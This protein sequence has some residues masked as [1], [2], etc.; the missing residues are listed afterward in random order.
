MGPFEDISQCS[1]KA[2]EIQGE[3]N[4]ASAAFPETG[5]TSIDHGLTL[6]PSDRVELDPTSSVQDGDLDALWGEGQFD[7]IEQNR[8]ENGDLSY[9]LFDD[10][11]QLSE[12]PSKRRKI[13]GGILLPDQSAP[14]CLPR[15]SESPV[16]NEESTRTSTSLDKPGGL[17]TPPYIIK[18]SPTDSG[19]GNRPTGPGSNC[20]L[21]ESTL[22]N[23]LNLQL[24]TAAHLSK[25]VP[26]IDFEI[27]KPPS[28]DSEGVEI[29]S[30][31]PSSQETIVQSSNL[32]SVETRNILK[33]LTHAV[34]ANSDASQF[35]L[36]SADRQDL[37][38]E[39]LQSDNSPAHSHLGQFD[40]G[41]GDSSTPVYSQFQGG[42]SWDRP[43]RAD[44]GIDTA[45]TSNSDL[46]AP[47]SSGVANAS[48]PKQYESPY[49]PISS[50]SAALN[51][52]VPQLA[53][54]EKG[55]NLRN[56]RHH[57]GK[58]ASSRNLPGCAGELTIDDHD[59]G[60]CDASSDKEPQAPDSDSS[61]NQGRSRTSSITEEEAKQSPKYD[62]S[63]L[64]TQLPLDISACIAL[65]EPVRQAHIFLTIAKIRDFLR[66]S[67]HEGC[68]ADSNNTPEIV[69][70]AFNLIRNNISFRSQFLALGVKQMEADIGEPSRESVPEQSQKV[71]MV[72][73][74]LETLQVEAQ[75]ITVPPPIGPGPE[76]AL[77][78][79]FSRGNL[80]ERVKQLIDFCSSINRVQAA[81]EAMEKSL[82]QEVTKR[83]AIIKAQQQQ[84]NLLRNTAQTYKNA[85]ETELGKP[86]FVKRS[87]CPD[88]Y[89][90]EPLGNHAW[91]CGLLLNGGVCG[92]R[93][94]EYVRGQD[95]NQFWAKRLKC[96]GCRGQTPDYLRHRI[97]NEHWNQRD[98]HLP[99]HQPSGPS[100]TSSF[101]RHPGS[102]SDAASTAPPD[103][104]SQAPQ[105]S[106]NTRPPSN[107]GSPGPASLG[108]QTINQS[109]LP[110]AQNGNTV[111]APTNTT[112]PSAAFAQQLGRNHG[113]LQNLPPL[114]TV[115]F[116][117]GISN[118][119]QTSPPTNSPSVARQHVYGHHN[120]DRDQPLSQTPNPASADAS[121]GASFVP[122]ANHIAP[123]PTNTQ[124]S[125][126]KSRSYY[127]PP[128]TQI[129]NDQTADGAVNG[130]RVNSMSPLRDTSGQFNNCQGIPQPIPLPRASH[131]PTG[132]QMNPVV[133]P[134]NFPGPHNRLR[135]P[136]F[137]QKSHMYPGV[138]ARTP[139]H[140][141]QS[142]APIDY[143]PAIRIDGQTP[144]VIMPDSPGEQAYLY[145]PGSHRLLN[146]PPLS[147][148]Q[149]ESFIQ[150]A[151]SNF[152][153]SSNQHSIPAPQV[154]L[155]AEPCPQNPTLEEDGFM[156][157]D[158]RKQTTSIPSPSPT[159]TVSST[160]QF[161]RPRMPSTRSAPPVSNWK[162]RTASVGA[163]TLPIVPSIEEQT[164]PQ[165]AYA[166]QVESRLV[167]TDVNSNGKRARPAPK[168]TAKKPASLP[169][170]E[171]PKKQRK[172]DPVA[173][174]TQNTLRRQLGLK[175][176][177]WMSPEGGSSPP[178][179]QAPAPSAPI[180]IADDDDDEQD[181][182]DMSS[183]FGNGNEPGAVERQAMPP[184]GNNPGS[185][186]VTGAAVADVLSPEDLYA[187]EL[188]AELEADLEAALEA[189]DSNPTLKELDE[190]G[191]MMEA[192][193]D[194]SNIG[195]VRDVGS[196]I[197]EWWEQMMEEDNAAAA[198]SSQESV[199]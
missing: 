57:A 183:L 134:D 87:D 51:P 155:P 123:P 191:L 58:R 177:S 92:I 16:Q 108:A 101:S 147:Y 56:Q 120:F 30:F 115:D 14:E 70:A 124:E 122:T 140:I 102:S 190:V 3:G 63:Y 21:A 46:K 135:A 86:R 18:Y 98:V 31:E 138:E 76:Y 77:W 43:C 95:Q 20:A 1:G 85:A 60:I 199:E 26:P 38:T 182:S 5:P 90:T 48:C 61:G 131:D 166:Q 112:R 165:Q 161:P 185:V 82:Q 111:P 196:E 148:V 154:P 23:R 151:M 113:L 189:G 150:Q 117:P 119:I 144:T 80:M 118:A 156:F 110:A 132:Q 100:Q 186:G 4:Y 25:A 49:A 146:L 175:T 128:P 78:L 142:P 188:E 194:D 187:K 62:P 99:R 163:L 40:G 71:D 114:Q 97:L 109:R 167:E 152:P 74:L 153:G 168:S 126:G 181:S 107:A 15:R 59:G 47:P 139:R 149:L 133:G 29:L 34:A 33:A 12:P 73:R 198:A 53:Q 35:P 157:D 103:Q 32:P 8:Q 178:A 169:I 28:L 19:Y 164:Q 22:G 137:E 174:S 116:A 44:G 197:E 105:L 104:A 81:T 68:L 88:Q 75:R 10:A 160:E 143:A 158:V 89:V 180:V 106:K 83:D 91:H 17:A 64:I 36:T 184:V 42:N 192:G 13:T 6:P 79:A 65:T 24:S 50:P 27:G 11:Y 7:V 41:C 121:F 9:T 125:I 170:P 55:I 162:T 67:P 54:P 136:S 159:E 172:L 195:E 72:L 94:E 129:T 37:H 173:E 69:N 66:N 84:I 52:H 93:N 2:I 45:S 171:P 130:S 127:H 179:P 96:V 141:P 176:R 145:V 193:N 39:A